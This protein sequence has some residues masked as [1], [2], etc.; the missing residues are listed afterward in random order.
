MTSAKTSSSRPHSLLCRPCGSPHPRR[1]HPD[2][3]ALQSLTAIKQPSSACPLNTTAS[4]LPTCLRTHHASSSAPPETHPPI[5]QSCTETPSPRLDIFPID[6]TL[7]V[8]RIVVFARPC[9]TYLRLL[10]TTKYAEPGLAE[11]ICRWLAQLKTPTPQFAI[12]KH[13]AQHQRQYQANLT[14]STLFS[15]A[16]YTSFGSRH[17]PEAPSDVA[18]QSW[19]PRGDA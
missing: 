19:W 2:T 12:G 9:S 1:P 5:N 17:L 15:R 4:Y 14:D 10:S 16:G 7:C 18:A 11:I 3:H 8:Q 13:Q 6:S